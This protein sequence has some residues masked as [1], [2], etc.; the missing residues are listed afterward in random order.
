VPPRPEASSSTVS[1]VAHDANINAASNGTIRRA[2][3]LLA[4]EGTARQ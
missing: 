2:V 4:N 1:L 3:M